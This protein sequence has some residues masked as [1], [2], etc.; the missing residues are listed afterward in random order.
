MKQTKKIEV[1]KLRASRARKRCSV[2]QPIDRSR[3]RTSIP[4]SRTRRNAYAL[5]SGD[6]RGDNS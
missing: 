5:Y 4:G 3:S 6:H 1:R 2:D